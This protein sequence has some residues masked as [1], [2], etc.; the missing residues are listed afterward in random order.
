MAGLNELIAKL[1]RFERGDVVD[2]IGK[3]IA[4]A[5]HAACIAGFRAQSDPYGV[6]WAPRKPP[7]AWAALAF[8]LIDN[9]HRILDDTGAMVGSLKARYS[10]GTVLMSIKGY[11][12]FHQYGTSNMVA[13][14]IFPDQA[15]GLGNWADPIQ[16]A[17]TD[18]VRELMK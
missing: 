7:K 17:A 12:Q 5:C 1:Q 6:P 13:R 9:G 4:N 11:A 15:Q 2:A 18:A 14:K 8:G 3:S 16:R 10:R